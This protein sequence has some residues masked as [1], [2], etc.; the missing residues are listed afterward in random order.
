[1]DRRSCAQRE[2]GDRTIDSA[3]TPLK[4]FYRRSL[5]RGEATINPLVGV[6]KPAVRTK[7]RKVASPVEAAA[8]ITALDRPDASL[9]ATAFYAGLR[10]GELIGLRREDVDLAIGLIH[11]RRGWDLREG[12]EVPTKTAKG[13]RRVPIPAIV[14]DH[15]DALPDDGPLFGSPTWIAK[16]NVRARKRWEAAGLE[17]ITLH[18][19]RH[20]YA[21]LMIAAGVNAKTLST[22]M[23]HATIAITL[24]LY[25]HLLP[26]SEDQAA[27]CS[28]L[29]S[30]ARS[31]PRLSRR[32]SRTPTKSCI[33]AKCA[34]VSHLTRAQPPWLRSPFKKD[35]A[36]AA[37]QTP[38]RLHCLGDPGSLS[39]NPATSVCVGK[40]AFSRAFEDCLTPFGLVLSPASSSTPGCA[41]VACALTCRT[42]EAYLDGCAWL[43]WAS[44]S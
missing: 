23:G 38:Q 22:F 17:P 8:M 15:L 26:G 6:L 31:A 19:A 1:M 34:D 24:D 2:A 44:I 39:A 32:P 43:P 25:G 13:P 33:E 29:I 27:S 16:T 21:S 41:A 18:E 36:A 4:A 40:A 11:V 9:W 37:Y 5:V 14:R 28:M 30:R 42:N 10:R 3:V 35:F 20:T 12:G 7:T